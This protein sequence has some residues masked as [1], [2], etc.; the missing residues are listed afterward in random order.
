[1]GLLVELGP[2]LRALGHCIHREHGYAGSR[3]SAESGVRELAL[4]SPFLLSRR[5]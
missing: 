3:E 5:L 4:D 1:M 2:F